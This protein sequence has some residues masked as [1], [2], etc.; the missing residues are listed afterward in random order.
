MLFCITLRGKNLDLNVCLGKVRGIQSC[1]SDETF[2]RAGLKL[3]LH[4][5]LILMLWRLCSV[6]MICGR[7]SMSSSGVSR[8]SLHCAAAGFSLALCLGLRERRD[9]A[10]RPA[11][12]SPIP[13]VK[14]NLLARQRLHSNKP[15]TPHST[16][17]NARSEPALG[18]CFLAQD[19]ISLSPRLTTALRA[20][21]SGVEHVAGAV[22]TSRF[23][24]SQAL[25]Y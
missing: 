14:D 25:K 18:H 15:R 17:P 7:M 12:F 19:G 16:N 23:L 13:S 9:S 20:R 24:R 11:C 3:Q 8:S 5:S 4:M 10:W 6:S 22:L 21:C 2:T 1:D